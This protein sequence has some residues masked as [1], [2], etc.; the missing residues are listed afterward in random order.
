MTARLQVALVVVVAVLGSEGPAMSD[1]EDARLGPLFAELAAAASPTEAMS[2][3]RQIWAIWFDAGDKD[4][5]RRMGDGTEAMDQGDGLTALAAFDAV[6]AARPGFAEG[7]NRRATLYFLM[8]RFPESVADIEQTLALEPRHF[9]AL[10]GLAMIREAQN[11]PFAALEALERVIRVYPR[12][13]QLK[14]R[15]DRLTSMLGEAI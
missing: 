6:I 4:V 9:G 13:P 12:M 1:Q 3:E 11:E 5:N 10:S 7:W 14:E 15:I 8:R 2:V